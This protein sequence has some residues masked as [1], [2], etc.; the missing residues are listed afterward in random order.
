MTIQLLTG[1]AGSGK[2]RAAIAQVIAQIERDPFAT[3]WVVLPT[4]LHG[5]QFRAALLAELRARQQTSAYFGVRFFDF[6]DLYRHLLQISGD[7]QRRINSA[8]QNR[9]LRAAVGQAMPVLTHFAPIADTPGFVTLLAAFFRELKQ[10]RITPAQLSAAASDDKDRD[11]AQIYG[12]YQALLQQHDLVDIEGE[13]WLALAR[14]AEGPPDKLPQPVALL[15]IDG[16]DQFNRVQA[17]LIGLLSQRIRQTVITLTFQPERAATAHR[18]FAQTRARLSQFIQWKEGHIDSTA[19]DSTRPAALNSLSA[20]LFEPQPAAIRTDAVQFVEAADPRRE[21]ELALRRIK[22]ELLAG[23]APEAIAL[24]ARDLTPYAAY[25]SEYAALYGLPLRMRLSQAIAENAAIAALLALID[26]A[27]ADFP[28]RAVIDSLRSPYWTIP[29]LDSAAV[30]TLDRISRQWLVIAGREQWREALQRAASIPAEAAVSDDENDDSLPPAAP[31]T[32][33]PALGQALDRFFARVTPP[34]S[35]TVDAYIAWL[36]ALIGPDPLLDPGQVNAAGDADVPEN[37]AELTDTLSH[38][39]LLIN[40]RA[41][42]DSDS[43]SLSI[44]AR[45]LSALAAFKRQLADLSAAYLLL[46]N[47]GLLSWASFRAD[48]G[49]VIDTTAVRLGIGGSGRQ[50]RILVGSVFELRGLPHALVYVLGLGEG[51]FPLRTAEDALYL[52]G[53][54]AALN[55]GLQPGGVQVLTR[56]EQADE[57]SLFYELSVLAR[58]TLILSRPYS[59]NGNPWPPS[60]FWLAAQA[61]INTPPIRYPMAYSPPIEEAASLNEVL[62]A[63]MA[64]LQGD[65]PTNQ[66]AAAAQWLGAQVDH[67]RLWAHTQRVQAIE[68]ARLCDPHSNYRGI[69]HDE[70]LLLT[71]S[72]ELG[73]AHVWSAAQFNEYAQCPFGFF[74]KRLLRLSP[75][76]EPEPGADAR[77][78]GSLQHAILEQT[79]RQLQAEGL[80]IT[81]ENQPRALVIV[82]AVT[83]QEC[84]TAPARY[85]FR[86]DTLWAQRQFSLRA[87]LRDLIRL[88]FSDNSPLSAV[89]PG[90]RHI[91]DQ[92]AGF[93]EFIIEGTAGPLRVRGRIDRIDSDADQRQVLVIDY[94]SGSTA[95]SPKT[96]VEG[97]NIQILLYTAAIWQ[98]IDP[99]PEAVSGAFWHLPT[100]KLSGRLD[101]SEHA[102]LISDAIAALHE[103]V[104]NAR[105]AEFPDKPAKLEGGKCTRYCEFS[106]LC[107]I[108]AQT[109]TSQ[110]D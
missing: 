69:L 56:A 95:F 45:D 19:A 87:R 81:P 12:H 2:T 109:S 16:F 18:R 82:E 38:F 26:L 49:S 41:S 61:V 67:A 5:D 22:R 96:L 99:A 84:A 21:V 101:T 79:Y 103:R 51:Q 32:D 62:I 55:R 23:L 91:Y 64:G 100:Q 92:E 9:I 17:E 42:A 44:S 105:R 30:D 35:A 25:I 104:I 37:A 39:G 89:A 36:E 50:G 6:Y 60:P 108:R 78:L 98:Q 46:D 85:G 75:L 52:D 80:R 77:Q 66:A 34:V 59:D 106:Q 47:N 83:E 72:A 70:R 86:A 11:L 90:E 7:P 10:A 54:R 68:Q 31:L 63:V 110:A 4:D 14:I 43:A 53:E 13:G 93:D 88:D 76:I 58:Q 24:V 94:K 97:R 15:L 3:I 57:A 65:L 74:S 102:E 40:C 28:R 8:A 33:W 29:G 107:R 48:L 73:A 20:S 71:V 27:A 1:A